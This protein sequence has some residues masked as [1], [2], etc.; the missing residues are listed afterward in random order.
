VLKSSKKR[1]RM[2]RKL[3]IPGKEKPYLMAHR[4]NNVVCPENTL[5]AFRQAFLDGADI[6]ETDLHL[7]K[8][9]KFVCLHD[10]TLDRTTDRKGAVA[11]L[12]LK[13]I[14]S[15]SAFNQKPGFENERIPLL[16]ETAAVLPEN[17]ALALELKTDRF[18]EETVC[19]QLIS[20]LKNSQILERTIVLS[21]SAP[22]VFSVQKV[23]SEM[24]IGLI[25]MKKLK[26]PD[27]FDMVG[28]FFPILWLNPWYIQS[29]HHK[30][31][32]VC[33]LD[34]APEPRL[35]RYLGWGCD[36]IITNNPGV[37]RKAMDELLHGTVNN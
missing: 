21:F 27:D 8:D 17:V 35:K 33:P 28:P 7:S 34:P 12:T 6:L 9:G 19:R 4:G 10:A 26:P 3:E 37:T 29:A 15:A 36:A 23:Y 2:P 1:E 22:R 5:A 18:L 25:T 16:E 32:L 13:E 24:P 31:V 14:K 11:D 30:N 20:E